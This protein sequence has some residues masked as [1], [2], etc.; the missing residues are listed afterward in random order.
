MLVAY[1]DEKLSLEAAQQLVKMAEDDSLPTAQG[2]DLP[3]ML[4]EDQAQIITKLLDD[5]NQPVH[6][7]KSS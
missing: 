2:A 4:T 1:S 7:K 3:V 6:I 5:P